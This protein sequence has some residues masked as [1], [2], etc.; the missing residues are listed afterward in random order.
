MSE[1]DGHH[2]LSPL[3]SSKP[4][5]H[6]EWIGGEGI[7]RERR[8]MKLKSYDISIIPFHLFLFHQSSISCSCPL[9]SPTCVLNKLVE[10]GHALE[11]EINII[12]TGQGYT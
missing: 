7:G 2:S 6:Q 8:E 11:I 3:A 1:Q 12:L 10:D 4:I 5:N 9:S